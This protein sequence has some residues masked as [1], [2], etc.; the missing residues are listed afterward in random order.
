MADRFLAFPAAD[1][2]LVIALRAFAASKSF[3]DIR[4]DRL[5][6]LA[7]LRRVN[8]A[9]RAVVDQVVDLVRDKIRSVQHIE[10]AVVRHIRNRIGCVPRN[11]HRISPA[12]TAGFRAAYERFS[13]A[14]LPLRRPAAAL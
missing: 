6:R 4:S 3:R 12:Q 9:S 10:I 14:V 11:R 1:A 8:E 5:R 13:T 7:E 2:E